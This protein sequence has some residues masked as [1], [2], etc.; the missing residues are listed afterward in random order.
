MRM[1]V[2]LALVLGVAGSLAATPAAMAESQYD[3]RGGVEAEIR[4]SQPDDFTYHHLRV[5]IWRDGVRERYSHIRARFCRPPFCGPLG[6]DAVQVRDLDAD[7]E[8]EV[9]VDL[10]TG[11]A[12]CCEVTRIWSWS[13]RRYRSQS[14]FWGNV[15]YRLRDLSGS[16]APEFVSGDDRF[17]YAFAS[18]AFSGVPLRVLRWHDGDF[19]DVTR[20][21]KPALRRDAHRWMHAYRRLRRGPAESLGVL[22]AWVADEYLL[23]RRV[24]AN[25]FLRHELRAGRLGGD[26]FSGSGERFI[27]RLHRRLHRWGY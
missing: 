22:A 10:Y 4:Y 12:H 5:L 19:R 17:N 26:E 23:G 21:Q 8:P 11:G 27:A 2:P 3:A 1:L 16:P 14:V 15:F 25:H 6:E 13:G 9:L 7:G 24:H 20:S 18:Y